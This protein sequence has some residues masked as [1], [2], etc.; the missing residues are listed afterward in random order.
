MQVDR[1]C[2]S[3]FG[4]LDPMGVMTGVA[5]VGV[6]AMAYLQGTSSFA[7]LGPGAGGHAMS[8]IAWA[9]PLL[10]AA[11]IGSDLVFRY[12]EDVNVA[13]PD[14]LRFYPAI[15]V[16]VEIALHVVPIAVLVATAGDADRVRRDLWRIAIP[17]ALVEAV[18]QAAYATSVGTAV[19]SAVHLMV[20]GV[21]QVWIFWRFG[22]RADARFPP[23]LLLPVAPGLGRRPTGA[24]VLS[25][26][27]PVRP[28]SR[29][30]EER[31]VQV[32][33]DHPVRT[34]GRAGAQAT[35]AWSTSVIGGPLVGPRVQL[36]E[37]ESVV[38][39]YGPHVGAVR[40]G[41]L[42]GCAALLRQPPQHGLGD[43]RGHRP[44]GRGRLVGVAP[45]AQVDLGERAEAG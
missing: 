41:E 7:V 19:F 11:A 36:G 32:E 27:E 21:A 14:A 37:H 43:R 24:A 10:A 5:V 45:G 34:G 15:A 8:I 33:V 20:F 29:G 31:A 42:V 4:G 25:A 12:A 16:F 23:R 39:A 17:V 1:S 3:A 26:A 30:A 44:E 35:L 22:S 38:A 9:V 6:F 2:S 18:V 13:M 40:P 28:I